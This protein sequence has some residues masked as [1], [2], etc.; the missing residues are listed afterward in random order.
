MIT[1]NKGEWSEL[2]TFLK[3]LSDRKIFES[4]EN[5]NKLES[6]FYPILKVIR[7][8]SG[9]EKL[10][11]DLVKSLD[12]ICVVNEEGTEMKIIPINTISSK[13]NGIFF[14]IKES[15]QTFPIQEAEE[16]MKELECK[17][18]K[19]D[20]AHKS[21]LNVIIHDIYT[22]S[23][24]EV[25]FS[26]K[27]MVGGNATLL[28]ASF[29]TNFAYEIENTNEFQVNDVNAQY[30]TEEG[31]SKVKKLVSELVSQ[32]KTLKF[33]GTQSP[34]FNNNLIKVDT[35]F[36]QIIGEIVKAYYLSEGVHIP[37][38]VNTI[39]NSQLFEKTYN[40]KLEDLEF[41]VKNFLSDVAI[42][43]VP[44]KLWDGR[45]QV[46]GGYLIVRE[47]GEVVSFFVHNMDKFKD[48]LYANTFLD[49]P[50]TSRHQ[51]GKIYSK[52]GKFYLNL[53]LQIR[54]IQ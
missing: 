9:R 53:N 17:T 50:S 29:H 39:A 19:T 18:V 11:Y 32:G 30:M 14:K 44:G 41:K 49:T 31:K 35:I 5:L 22:Q 7:Q 20:S 54:Y 16:L 47:D 10:I 36:P 37:E 8:E 12:S 1:A 45:S 21:D 28:N 13:I 3:I 42:G 6:V 15:Q 51:F 40:L 38:L 23:A 33:I 4:D 26:V 43:M 24:Q 27:S 2:Y 52:D 48:Y 46:R 34:I 25:G